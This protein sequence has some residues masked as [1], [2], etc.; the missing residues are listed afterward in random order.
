VRQ[1]L[2]HEEMSDRKTSQ[3]HRQLKSLVPELPDDFRRTI[4][5]RRLPPHVQAILAGQTEGSLDSA[6]HLANRICKVT[7]LPTT[8]S[9]SPS[10]PD[11]TAELLEG[12]EELSR[13]V[14]SL[15]A[16]QTHSRPHA[17]IHQQ[18][19]SR[20][21]RDSTS[22]NTLQLNDTCW[23]NWQFGDNARKF[24]PPCWR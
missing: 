15:Q 5:A 9:I 1:H 21:L 13:Q 3:F 19:H 4:W 22:D 8:S 17:R 6:S 11:N 16:S 18:L 14:A 24:T 7:T 20:D 12:I 23:Y 2:S 10:Q